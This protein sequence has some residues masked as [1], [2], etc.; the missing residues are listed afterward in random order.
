VVAPA[1]DPAILR[2][3]GL[4]PKRVERGTGA[5]AQWIGLVEQPPEVVIVE[6]PGLPERV[7]RRVAQAHAVVVIGRGI[8]LGIDDLLRIP[9]IARAGGRIAVLREQLQPIRID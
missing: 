5:M 6:K 2:Q 4:P 8:A 3:A 7:S 9:A 1:L